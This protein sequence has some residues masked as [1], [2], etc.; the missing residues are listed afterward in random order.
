MPGNEG[1]EGIAGCS[2]MLDIADGMQV[3]AEKENGGDVFMCGGGGICS[4]TSSCGSNFMALTTLSP[5]VV[6][7][8]RLRDMSG[9]SRVELGSSD[10]V[11]ESKPGSPFINCA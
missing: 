5:S 2:A 9:A 1:T 7:A 10:V 3:G 11:G 4:E 8:H 6:D